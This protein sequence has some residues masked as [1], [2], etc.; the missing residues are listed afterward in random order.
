[1]M[2]QLKIKDPQKRTAKKSC[3]GGMGGWR[4]VKASLRIAYGN[5]KY[6]DQ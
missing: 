5:Q 3:P 6:V 4:K 2:I 1:M